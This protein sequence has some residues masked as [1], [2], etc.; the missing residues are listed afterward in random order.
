MTRG[1]QAIGSVQA[2]RLD[3]AGHW[4]NVLEAVTASV[5][6]TQPDGNAK[7]WY[8]GKGDGSENSALYVL[9]TSHFRLILSGS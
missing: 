5:E 7:N 8:R 3:Q 9:T 6:D 1:T 2:M 4:F